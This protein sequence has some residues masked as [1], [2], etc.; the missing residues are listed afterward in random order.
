MKLKKSII[1]IVLCSVVLT[2]CG[3]NENNNQNK[4]KTT[5]QNEGKQ[6]SNSSVIFEE[7]D[8]VKIEHI[9]GIGYVGNENELYL[10]THHGLVK[11]AGG[12]WYTSIKNKHDYMG[13]QATK[14]GFYSSGHPEPGSDLKNP[15]GLIK[16]TDTGKSFQKLTLYGETDFHYLAAGYNSN[17][18]YVLNQE[19]NSKLKSSG[20][21][22]TEDEGENWTQSKMQG[23][24][25]SSIGN[26][27]THPDKSNIIG[28]SSD[29]GVFISDNHG[30][31]F[32]MVSK[33]NQITALELQENSLLYYSLESGSPALYK[34]NIS[35]QKNIE[36]NTPS[37]INEENPVMFIASNPKKRDEITVVTYKNDIYQ[38]SDN[39]AT[40]KTL[41]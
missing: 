40:W 6:A 35:D 37:E 4:Q 24:T 29:K 8:D 36:L 19:P 14:E 28:I 26:I 13:F 20:L 9:H 16:S 33:A 27:A 21:F 38:T 25:A 15:L 1:T 39:G 41:K 31:D 11:Y 7:A 22:Y 23:F 30:E 3:G 5:E 10:A 17:I 12:K 18:I 34:Q 2:A 32:K